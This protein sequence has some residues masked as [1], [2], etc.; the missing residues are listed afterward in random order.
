MTIAVLVPVKA[1]R[2]AKERLAGV[3]DDAARADLAR[4]MA[5]TVLA[6][7]KDLPLAVV[8]DDDEVAAWARAR[9]ADVVW[10]PGRGLNGAVAD[11]VEHLAEAG[12]THVIVAHADLPLAD[13]LARI[14]AGFAGVTLV[15]DRRRDGTNV[16]CLPVRS[17]FEFHYGPRSFRRHQREAARLG[18]PCR[19]LVDRRLAW[20][21]DEPDDLRYEKERHSGPSHM[22]TET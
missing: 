18:L 1:F 8:C 15:P 11:G 5:A 6:A 21:V 17:G 3:L 14:A 16:L 4:S 22:R 12:A 20:D 7:A 13:D 2:H 9:R 10:R 19:V